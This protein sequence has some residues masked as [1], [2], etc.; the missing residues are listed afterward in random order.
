MDQAATWH[1]VGF[2]SVTK[3]TYRIWWAPL[4][5]G[6]EQI[7]RMAYCTKMTW[8]IRFKI[9]TYKSGRGM[10]TSIVHA[11]LCSLPPWV[12]FH[13]LWLRKCY[14]HWNSVSLFT[15]PVTEVGVVWWRHQA[16]H[17]YFSY[18]AGRFRVLMGFKHYMFYKA[19]L[20][21]AKI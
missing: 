14:K 19:T 15:V 11:H 3:V 8:P 1:G 20:F 5:H 9:D 2:F 13:V 16:M 21:Q 6:N 7:K 12:A 18:C 10:M 17:F 4:S